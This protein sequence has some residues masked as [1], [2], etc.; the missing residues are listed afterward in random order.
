MSYSVIDGLVF[1]YMCSDTIG[2]TSVRAPAS[3][4]WKEIG[5]NK[6]LL[7]NGHKRRRVTS[8]VFWTYDAQKWR[9]HGKTDY[10]RLIDE[11]LKEKKNNSR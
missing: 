7:A 8:E 4:H 6:N 3:G 10:A 9:K 2:W 11:N 1:H 5:Q